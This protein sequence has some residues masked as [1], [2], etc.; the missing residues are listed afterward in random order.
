MV[1]LEMREDLNTRKADVRISGLSDELQDRVARELE[2]A[3]SLENVRLYLDEVTA[4]V[5]LNYSAAHV[6]AWVSS[7]IAHMVLIRVSR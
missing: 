6:Y 5:K 3:V 2:H 4:D 1:K 7:E